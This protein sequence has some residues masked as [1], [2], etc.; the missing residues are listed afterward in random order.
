MKANSGIGLEVAT[1]LLAGASNHVLLGARSSEK[2]KAAVKDLQSLNLPGVVELL[3]IDVADEDS[4]AAAAKVVEST[5]GRC[6][7]TLRRDLEY[8][9]FVVSNSS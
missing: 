3:Q 7:C 6:V 2:G 1:Q 9:S 8:S 4:V 5:H